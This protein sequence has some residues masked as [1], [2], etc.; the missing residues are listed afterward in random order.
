MTSPTRNDFLHASLAA[1]VAAWDSYL[2]NVVSEFINSTGNPMDVEFAAIHL[3]LKEFVNRAL[4]KFNTPNSNNSRLLL[5]N[6][7]GY[8]PIN[9]WK[10]SRAN[11]NATET[12]E[13][14]DQILK[15]RHSFAHGSTIPS[16]PWTVTPSGRR[17]LNNR[18]LVRIDKFLSHLVNVTDL[19]LLRHGRTNFPSKNLW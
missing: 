17:Q 5:I 14:L 12:R 10:W 2:N 13:Y 18:A 8:D 19:G 1:Y 15:V 6:C 4:K 11:L 7:T 9:D 16:L 3:R